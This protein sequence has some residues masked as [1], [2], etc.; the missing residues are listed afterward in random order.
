MKL[1]K[2]M[3]YDVAFKVSEEIAATADKSGKDTEAVGGFKYETIGLAVAMS[4]S[5]VDT[6][7]D[8]GSAE[9][10]KD[11]FVNACAKWSSHGGTYGLLSML[12]SGII[13]A[14]MAN[15][16]FGKDGEASAEE[17]HS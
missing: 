6:K 8:N 16:L 10:S 12:H 14:K 4:K 15:A 3:L 7:F 2:D 5:I 13:S 1:T 11:D 17:D 9:M